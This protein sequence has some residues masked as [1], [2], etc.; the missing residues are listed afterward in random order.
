M[1]RPP[2]LSYAAHQWFSRR[3]FPPSCNLS[4]LGSGVLRIW[5]RF[6]LYTQKPSCILPPTVLIITSPETNTI[7]SYLIHCLLFHFSVSFILLL[8]WAHLPL[9]TQAISPHMPGWPQSPSHLYNLNLLFLCLLFTTLSGSTSHL[10][11]N[12]IYTD[13]RS[14]CVIS[15][16]SAGWIPLF[17][18]QLQADVSNQHKASL[19]IK[20][21]KWDS[22]CIFFL[23]TGRDSN[24]VSLNNLA[25]WTSL[26]V[27]YLFFPDLL[28]YH[29][30][31][32][33]CKLCP[34]PDWV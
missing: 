1:L 2:L 30:T 5:P 29:P 31:A 21:D 34:H 10:L 8:P 23:I 22:A 26:H 18:P 27:I 32:R 13:R 14:L 9:S 20:L 7:I 33:E 28:Q 11:L 3:C 4:L 25:V 16:L 17:C 24:N 12:F 19:I 6:S 15:W